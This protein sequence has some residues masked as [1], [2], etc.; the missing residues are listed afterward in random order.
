MR[1]NVFWVTLCRFRKSCAVWQQDQSH[2]SVPR[3]IWECLSE[4]EWEVIANISSAAIR[5][6]NGTIDNFYKNN[7][8]AADQVIEDI[9]HCLIVSGVMGTDE[10]ACRIKGKT[11]WA[12]I[13]GQQYLQR[14]WY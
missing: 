10:T 7:L 5:L 2:R 3:L 14:L 13:F 9:K 6:A 11:N 8:S 1:R 12:Q 4:Q